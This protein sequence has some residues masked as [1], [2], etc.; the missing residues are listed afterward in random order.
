MYIRHVSNRNKRSMCHRHSH[1]RSHFLHLDIAIL[2]VIAVILHN[3]ISCQ[4]L[5]EI[6]LELLAV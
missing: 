5:C 3:R 2:L 1:P 4:K 6:A